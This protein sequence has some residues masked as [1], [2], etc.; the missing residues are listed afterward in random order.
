MFNAQAQTLLNAVTATGAGEAL[1][2]SSVVTN[3]THMVTWGGTVPTNTVVRLEG[4][5]DGVNWATLDSQTVTATNSIYFVTGKPVRY[6]RGNYVSK[7]GGDG[8]T[9]VTHKVLC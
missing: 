3:F 4:S 1:D 5:I 7:S 2:L 6:I 8:T 9:S